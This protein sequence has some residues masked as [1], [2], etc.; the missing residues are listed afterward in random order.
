MSMGGL[1]V[2]SCNDPSCNV[3][4]GHVVGSNDGTE[5]IYNSTVIRA[6]DNPVIAYYDQGN[7]DLKVA[8]CGDADCSALAS[9]TITTLDSTG[10]V[11]SYNSI[12]LGAD[13][14]PIIA[15]YDATNA[16]LKVAACS[17][18]TC[19]SAT[20]TSYAYTSDF[21]SYNS[22]AIGA[23]NNPIIS[24]ISGAGVDLV[25]CSNPTCTS[26]TP[27][28]I[29]MLEPSSTPAV[30]AQN[31]SIA[32]GADN[33]PIISLFL[34]GLEPELI[35]CEDAACSS[36]ATTMTSAAEGTELLA[37]NNGSYLAVG[38]DGLP[39]IAKQDSASP[40]ALSVIE[41]GNAQCSSGNTT[42]E[43]VAGSAF[44][45]VREAPVSLAIRESDNARIIAYH[46]NLILKIAIL[47]AP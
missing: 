15:Y 16:D 35:S 25:L 27:R 19:T 44:P 7:K 32:I 3:A 14:N 34:N 13:N 40:Y 36:I 2:W 42:L 9:D 24:E 5:G 22:I 10:D 23:D 30:T 21:G 11:G 6:D 29:R 43:I 1:K 41:C 20:I 17:N 45:P 33:N 28:T 46:D 8:V 18:T 37:G 31:T 38:T 39:V 26:S 12:A 4:F 47:D